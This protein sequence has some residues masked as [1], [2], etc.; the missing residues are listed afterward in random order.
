MFPKFDSSNLREN[1][2]L[3]MELAKENNPS[4]SFTGYILFRDNGN[5]WGFDNGIGIYLCTNKDSAILKQGELR[6][7]GE[8]WVVIEFDLYKKAVYC[9]ADTK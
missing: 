5:V 2:R 1:I 7:L 6:A 8:N 4:P 3:A 9:V